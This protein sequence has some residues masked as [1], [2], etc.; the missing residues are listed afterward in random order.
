[1]RNKIRPKTTTLTSVLT[2]FIFSL[3]L[4]SALHSQS[5]VA[6]PQARQQGN[7]VKQAEEVDTSKFPVLDFVSTEIGNEKVRAN[8]K[9]W[10]EALKELGCLAR[11]RAEYKGV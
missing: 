6:T 9:I 10:H 7:K 8:S 5:Q 2:F 3:I 11:K 4:I 1:M